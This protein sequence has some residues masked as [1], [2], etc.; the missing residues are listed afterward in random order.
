[1]SQSIPP[2]E[3]G[4]LVSLIFENQGNNTNK[5]QYLAIDSKNK[6]L[7]VKTNCGPQ[8]I[9]NQRPSPNADEKFTLYSVNNNH[10]MLWSEVCQG[11]LV[12]ACTDAAGFTTSASQPLAYNYALFKLNTDGNIIYVNDLSS[13]KIVFSKKSTSDQV[14]CWDE[15]KGSP[16]QT[17]YMVK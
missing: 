5:Y 9:E 17:F 8:P 4:M 16:D 7:C 12:T 2:F 14:I 13:P 15:V 3:N 6:T 1:M 11:Y 10:F